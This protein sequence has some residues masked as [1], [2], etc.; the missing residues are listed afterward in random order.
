MPHQVD[1]DAVISQFNRGGVKR[2]LAELERQGFAIVPRSASEDMRQAAY[3]TML[4]AS[5]PDA[6]EKAIEVGA[7]RAE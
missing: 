7:V 6:V 2:A 5:A 3:S 1:F 4:V